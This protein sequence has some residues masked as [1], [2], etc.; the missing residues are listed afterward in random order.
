M[1]T[2]L[3]GLTFQN[4]LNAHISDCLFSTGMYLQDLI[5]IDVAH[6]ST[7]GMDSVTRSTKVSYF[8]VRAAILTLPGI[9]EC[10]AQMGYFFTKNS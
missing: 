1:F 4:K 10:A 8:L 6:P 3:L 9:Q 5:Y 2:Q 7:G